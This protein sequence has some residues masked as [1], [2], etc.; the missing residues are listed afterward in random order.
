MTCS[1]FDELLSEIR[2]QITYRNTVMRA[3]V[4]SKERLALTLR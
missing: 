3:S 4:P 2:P 1:S